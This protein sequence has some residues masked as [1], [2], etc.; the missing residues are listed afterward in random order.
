MNTFK[1]F[2]S[3]ST[4][5][6]LFEALEGQ[7]GEREKFLISTYQK[8]WDY[9]KGEK[10]E[11]DTTDFSGFNKFKTLEKFIEKIGKV[12]PSKKG[13]YMQ[14][15]T[16]LV[17]KDPS[18]N[19]PE[20][21]DRLALDLRAFEEHS[22]KLTNKDI[23]AYKSFEDLYSAIEPHTKPREKTADEKKEARMNAQ[24]ATIKGQI[25]DVYK[26]P[27][28]WIKIPT[29]KKASQFLGQNTRWCTAAKS[30]D[31]NYFDSYSSRDVLF[32][33]YDKEKKARFQ[34]HI[35]SGSFADEADKMQGL[36]AVPAWAGKHISAWYKTNKAEK[37]SLKHIM[38]LSGFGD[39]EVGKGTEHEDV[40]D[41]MKQYGVL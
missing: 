13:T 3:E 1:S 17:L 2:L 41:L 27:E 10:D 32:V 34:L 11:R 31:S 19:K 36:K 38:T 5:Q 26:G 25:T 29:T 14:W 37:M 16:K 28:G 35:E 12:D 24:L 22:S 33:V 9:I 23:N 8:K 4:I 18:K 7:K 6:M 30:R 21:L 15:I 20:D 39:T 40:L